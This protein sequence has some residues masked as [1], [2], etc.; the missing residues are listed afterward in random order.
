VDFK[1]DP[2]S[3]TYDA[4]LTKV[5]EGTLVKVCS[6]YENEWAFANRMLG[7]ALAWARAG[8]SQEVRLNAPGRW[9]HIDLTEHFG[10]MLCVIRICTVN[11]ARRSNGFAAAPML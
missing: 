2:A 6:W 3:S 7:T 11:R 8:V 9:S 4:T 5:I 10:P 1:H